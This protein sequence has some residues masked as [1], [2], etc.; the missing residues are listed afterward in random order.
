MLKHALHKTEADEF[1]YDALDGGG[2][3]ATHIIQEPLH[4]LPMPSNVA[5]CSRATI[6]SLLVNTAIGSTLIA[7]ALACGRSSD[8]THLAS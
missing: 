1:R 5:A 3:D 6:P 4:F 7:S 2:V 8:G